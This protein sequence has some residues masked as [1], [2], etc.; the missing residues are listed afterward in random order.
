MKEALIVPSF[1]LS[2]QHKK[3]YAVGEVASS[4]L[5]LQTNIVYTKVKTI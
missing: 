2:N 4:Y 5:G 3:Y 1:E